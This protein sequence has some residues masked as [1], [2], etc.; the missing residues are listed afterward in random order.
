MSA[1]EKDK[2][3]VYKNRV[4][5]VHWVAAG[6]VLLAVWVGVLTHFPLARFAL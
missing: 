6:V 5:L 2:H 1:E 3:Q 4:R